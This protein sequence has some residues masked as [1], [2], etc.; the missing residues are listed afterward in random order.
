MK[1]VAFFGFMTAAL[2]LA[3]GGTL[4]LRKPAGPFT[5]GVFSSTDTLRVGPVDLSVMVQN[6]RD[7]SSVPD[8]D[9]KLHLTSST[10][11]GISEVFAPATHAKATNK[12][13][14]AANINLPSAGAWKLVVDVQAKPGNAEIAGEITVLPPQSRLAANWPYF[15]VVPLLAILFAINQWLRKKRSLPGPRA[16]A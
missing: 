10:R 1:R 16:R 14:Y 9:V 2:L 4:L 15:A 6:T 12:L 8:A 7:Q 3:D 11:G 5:I 13:L